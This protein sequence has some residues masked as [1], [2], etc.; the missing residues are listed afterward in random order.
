MPADAWNDFES[1]Q[2][3]QERNN[4]TVRHVDPST[5][6][7]DGNVSG[8]R[9]WLGDQIAQRF[10]QSSLQVSQGQYEQA[11][12]AVNDDLQSLLGQYVDVAGETDG[13]TGQDGTSGTDGSGGQSDTSP[14]E[15]LRNASEQQQRFVNAT[16]RYNRT[17]Q[18]YVQARENGNGQRARRIARQLNRLAQNVSTV[19]RN[20]TRSYGRVA[21]VTGTNL[22]QANR[23]V[24]RAVSNVTDRQRR[25]RNMSFSATRLTIQEPT[26]P[27]SFA[28]P[29]ALRG[30]LVTRNGSAVSN[31]TIRLVVGRQQL[32][33]TT[34]TEGTF[35]IPYRPTLVQTARGSLRVTYRPRLTAPYLGSQTSIPVDVQPTDPTVTVSTD[36]ERLQ[37]RDQVTIRGRVTAAN[38][39]VPNLPLEIRLGSQRLGTVTTIG[40][41]QFSLTERVP[42]RVSDGSQQVTSRVAVQGRAISVATAETTVTVAE[43]P[44]ALSLS[45]SRDSAVTAT[46]TLTTAAGRPIPNQQI[47]IVVNGTHVGTAQTNAQGVYTTTV[48]LPENIQSASPVD[49]TA[50]LETEGSNLA[51]ATETTTL[52]LTGNGSLPIVLVAAALLGSLAVG[53][54]GLWIRR[55]DMS[56]GESV[57]K[58]TDEPVLAE[59][60]A[61]ADGDTQSLQLRGQARA[62]LDTGDVRTA[63]E[64]AYAAVRNEFDD[65]TNT[66]ATHWEFYHDLGDDLP[67]EQRDQLRELTSWYEAAVFADAVD[68]ETGERVLETVDDL[69]WESVP[70]EIS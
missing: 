14:T 60:A 47:A 37:Y 69:V 22:T 29:L 7:E 16:R 61:D 21:A 45:V 12:K 1:V 65:Q 39:S 28:S 57:P 18:R 32:R 54:A 56:T 44:T 70:A 52:A 62:A 5:V 68:A 36:Q 55:R 59:D 24:E 27:V 33:A 11:D 43:Q 15:A 2:V 38:V 51:P 53:A 6:N 13:S 17:Y 31:R 26:E 46:G 49:I 48:K 19:S 50:R 42:A 63:V 40:S 35:T 64:L 34:T 23:S 10:E 66:A 58:T 3:D 20:V 30:R 9:V 67:D 41:G 8:V 4:S 25:V